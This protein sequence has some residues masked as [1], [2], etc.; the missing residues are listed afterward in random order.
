[1]KFVCLVIAVLLCGC[2]NEMERTR[3]L[4]REY[5]NT[6]QGKKETEER[7]KSDESHAAYRAEQ[8]KY[9]D[10]EDTSSIKPGDRVRVRRDVTDLATGWMTVEYVYEK[11]GVQMARCLWMADRDGNGWSNRD[12]MHDD[13]AVHVLQ[14]P[15]TQRLKKS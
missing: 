5:G 12:P 10:V 1:M 8:A 11:H 7:R 2:E 4:D 6:P 3:R 9:E 15:L 14:K 13:F